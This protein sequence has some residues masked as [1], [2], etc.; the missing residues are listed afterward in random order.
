MLDCSVTCR[1]GAADLKAC[2]AN[3]SC[4]GRKGDARSGCFEI[5][6]SLESMGAPNGDVARRRSD[7]LTASTCWLRAA[8]F[9]RQLKVRTGIA[10]LL[11]HL[12]H[13]CI[14]SKDIFRKLITLLEI[15]NLLR[16]QTIFGACECRPKPIYL[17]LFGNRSC[18]PETE[19]VIP[20]EMRPT[21]MKNCVC[22]SVRNC[23]NPGSSIIRHVMEEQEIL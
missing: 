22:L 17:D 7:Q 12:L 4:A 16:M 8:L 23:K 2:R 6:R 20:T 21:R 1:S 9:S 3:I 14:C 19:A 5:A 18:R 10:S 15:K 13:R 11:E